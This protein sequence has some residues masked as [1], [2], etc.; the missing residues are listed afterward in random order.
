MTDMTGSV[1]CS[2]LGREVFY[3]QYQCYGPG[4]DTSQRVWWSKSLSDDQAKPFLT[5]SF[6]N[7]HTWLEDENDFNP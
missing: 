2:L 6:V 5:D 3:G 4:S 1:V 7:A